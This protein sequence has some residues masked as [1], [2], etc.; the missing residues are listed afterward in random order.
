MPAVGGG[1]LSK[2]YSQT[3]VCMR[4]NCRAFKRQVPSSPEDAEAEPWDRA[5]DSCIPRKL[6]L[7]H[8][9]AEKTGNKMT[10]G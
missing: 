1:S 7:T 2:G 6:F 3:L 10:V 8:L 5:Q 4:L 9:G